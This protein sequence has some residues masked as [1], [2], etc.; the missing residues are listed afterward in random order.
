MQNLDDSWN[1]QDWETF[2]RLHAADC[3]V[4]WPGQPEPTRGRDRHVEEAKAFF[5]TFPDNHVSNHPY[6][7]F[8]I[9]GDWT[10]AIADFT[11]TMKGPLSIPT[12][13]TLPPTNKQ[14]HV[15]LCTIAYWSGKE[16]TKKYLFYDEVDFM[17]QIGYPLLPRTSSTFEKSAEEAGE[18]LG[19][20]GKTGWG[21]I[22]GFGKGFQ[23]AFSTTEEKKSNVHEEKS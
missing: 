22:R 15:N 1:T 14:F 2:R 12:G 9:Q 5:R 4:Y 18:L 13:G 19:R 16:L 21:A 6:Q 11:G 10:C 20:L 8:F 23:N 17:K 3:A 7:T